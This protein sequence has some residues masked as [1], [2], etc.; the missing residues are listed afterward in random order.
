MEGNKQTLRAILDEMKKLNEKID[1]Q[2]SVS[3][4]VSREAKVKGRV[5]TSLGSGALTSLSPIGARGAAAFKRG[6]V[7]GGAAG[8]AGG[9][10]GVAAVAGK[11]IVDAIQGIF[12]SASNAR[13]NTIKNASGLDPD[14]LVGA[15]SK[16]NS[17]FAVG[18]SLAESAGKL[19][20][21]LGQAVSEYNA[22]IQR[23]YNKVNDPFQRTQGGTRE[24]V[25]EA[26]SDFSRV[27]GSPPSDEAI[28][29]LIS[30]V[31]SREEAVTKGL[32]KVAK[33]MGD[34]E[35]NFL[36]STIPNVLGSISF[37]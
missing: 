9:A 35:A 11:S 12:T 14:S 22:G 15:R 26:V 17:R 3:S 21:I 2:G 20:P 33:I 18:D 30:A 6:A 34:Q 24:R 36:L 10:A 8:A 23:N 25:N 19:N 16:V 31:R 1:N 4:S 7:G 5:A 37:S 13:S 29:N 32:Q 28:K 27:T